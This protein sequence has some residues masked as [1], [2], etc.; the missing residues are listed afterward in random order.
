MDHRGR[1]IIKKNSEIADNV[2]NNQNQIGKSYIY[3]FDGKKKKTWA[4]KIAY[5]LARTPT[6]LS[7]AYVMCFV[8]PS[9]QEQNRTLQ[10]STQQQPRTEAKST[11]SP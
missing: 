7:E 10:K 8:S 9:P 5:L 3:S 11:Q 2:K 1:H 6:A 4:V